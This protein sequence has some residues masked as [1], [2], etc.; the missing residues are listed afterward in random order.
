MAFYTLALHSETKSC[1]SFLFLTGS[2]QCIGLEHDDKIVFLKFA[3]YTPIGKT[4]EIPNSVLEAFVE[5]IMIT[6]NHFEQYLRF[7]IPLQ[8][9]KIRCEQ[10]SDDLGE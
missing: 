4:R 9:S 8:F 5:N 7:V 2:Q 10:N 1:V 6:N 3:Q